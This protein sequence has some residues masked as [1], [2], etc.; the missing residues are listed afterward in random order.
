MSLFLLSSNLPIFMGIFIVL[1]KRTR[2]SFNS[3]DAFLLAI[4][5]LGAV[6][7]VI[8]EVLSLFHRL[9]RRTLGLSW[10]IVFLISVLILLFLIRR[11]F[12]TRFL[13]FSN[14]L[15]LTRS[16]PEFSRFEI[17]VWTL[18]GIQ[19]FTLGVVAYLYAPFHYDSMTYHL[20]RVM[21]W[22][23]NHT[24]AHYATNIDRQVQM[25]PFAEFI[26]LHMQILDKSDRFVNLVQWFAM[27][28]SVIG[29]TNIAAKLGA[30]R[31]QQSLSGLL[32]AFIPM[33][34]L[35]S[36]STQNDYVASL[37]IIIFVSCLLSLLMNP[38]SKLFA[39]GV[40]LAFGLALLTKGTVYVYTSAIAIVLLGYFIYCFRV[41]AIRT[42]T[43]I[44]VFALFLN[45]G[46]YLRNYSLYRSPLGP[47]SAYAN[48]IFTPGV[49]LSN[50]IRNLAM[51]VPMKTGVEAIDLADLYLMSWLRLIHQL[52]GLSPT[53]GRTSFSTA[54]D[55]FKPD[56]ASNQ[57]HQDYGGNP[58]HMLLLVAAIGTALFNPFFWRHFRYL[59]LVV[60]SLFLSFLLFSL[61]LKWQ[62][63]GSRL[64]LPLFVLGSGI[65]PLILFRSRKPAILAIP[66]LVALFGFNWTFNNISRP[67]S[68]SALYDMYLRPAGYFLDT[69]IY[70]NYDAMT[71]KIVEAECRTVGLAIGLDSWE[72]PIWM[73]FKEYDYAVRLEHIHVTN[74][75]ANLQ[76][77]DFNPCAIISEG[78]NPI[79]DNQYIFY[80]FA[81]YNLYIDA[82]L[83]LEPSK[84]NPAGFNVSP[85]LAVVLG[86][87]WYD[88]ETANGVRW[89]E[90]KG[91]LWIYTNTKTK[92]K[93]SFRPFIMHKD[94][95]FGTEGKLEAKGRGSAE[96]YRIIVSNDRISTIDVKLKPGFNPVVLTLEG[97]DFIPGQGETRSLGIA[98]YTIDINKI[99]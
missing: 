69:E 99:P 51:H 93:I 21:H 13:A 86:R 79:L 63:W 95:G 8:T 47:S 81:N 59:W 58:L 80:S 20:A 14:Q 27:L 60:L 34:I 33:G 3:R 26:L 43:A 9:D 87:G 91:V 61:Y 35:Q 23:Q 41:R 49:L 40:A 12:F 83:V 22:V 56:H 70:Q 39:G 11:R 77:V 78:T 67:V 30:N 2:C 57:Y 73:L 75:T 16:W 65:I 42:V 66:I 92:A 68:L 97:G 24:V 32:C 85:D 18:I 45:A 96:S 15:K 31:V 52:S 82:N 88:F 55:V 6:V 90:G 71:Q 53:D 74:A 17:L 29:V 54:Q 84:E 72:Y 64:Q 10:I 89:M 28:G 36:T 37:A 48:D 46:H 7:V 5:T 19:I 4:A 94:N 38:T 98:F 25:P 62:I 1:F 50:S 76:P 44:L